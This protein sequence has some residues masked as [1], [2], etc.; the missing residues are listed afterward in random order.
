[1]ASEEHT[2]DTGAETEESNGGG[3]SNGH[4][5]GRVAA[6]AAASGATAYAA[7][8]A[9]SSRSSSSDESDDDTAPKKKSKSSGSSDSSASLMTA[10]V[11]SGWDVAKDS[12]LPVVEDAATKAGAFVADRAPELVRDVVVP[13]FIAGFQRAKRGDQGESSDE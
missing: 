11:A 5:L 7:R 13:R 6:I 10:A 8:K 1:M 4:N 2:E 9:L 12:L 3:S